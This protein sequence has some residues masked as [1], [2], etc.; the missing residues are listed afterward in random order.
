[1]PEINSTQN[2]TRTN[3]FSNSTEY[4]ALKSA[5]RRTTSKSYRQYENYGGRG[6]KVCDRWNGKDGFKNFVKD[7]GLKPS[8]E[9]S[10]DRIDVNG[11]YSPENCRW[12]TRSTQ[13]HNQRIRKT[14]RSGYRGVSWD[15]RDSKWVANIW[16][17]LT[18][19]YL[20][21]S[22]DKEQAALYYDCAALQLYGDTAQTN[23]VGVS[24]C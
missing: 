18:R 24:Q 10:L 17:D 22:K 16:K 14:N 6:I 21:C 1:M 23:I 13:N 15:S 7:M 5:K 11:D 3:V 8:P 4:G 9:H 12:E 19:I 20:G 2:L